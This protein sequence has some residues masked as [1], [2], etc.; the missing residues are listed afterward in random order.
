MPIKETT[1]E[2]IIADA[3]NN[4]L[5]WDDLM[6]TGPGALQGNQDRPLAAAVQWIVNGGGADEQT[7]DVEALIGH[8]ARVDRWLM[9]T[10]TQG[11]VDVIEYDTEESAKVAFQG[12]EAELADWE[13]Q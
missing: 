13:C 9:R 10:N 2:M 11:F 3:L 7:G 1:K 6:Q 4:G 5:I 8:V 12:L